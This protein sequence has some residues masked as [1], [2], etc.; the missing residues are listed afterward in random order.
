MASVRFPSVQA[1]RLSNGLAVRT[2]EHPGPPLVTF[3]LTMPAGSAS[4]P[5]GRAGL[6]ALT[7]DLFDEGSEGRT[8]LEL[9]GA[10]DRIGARFGTGVG[11]DATTVSLTTLSRHAAAGLALLAEIVARPRFDE[12]D[13]ARVRELRRSRL[14]QLRTV[15]G[16]VADRVYLET[17]Y[18]AHP[19]GHLGIGTDVS[20]AALTVEHVR[21]FH[22]DAYQLGTATL[23]AVGALTHDRFV[24]AAERAFGEVPVCPPDDAVVVDD[25]KVLLR[26]GQQFIGRD[27]ERVG[28][29]HGAEAG[30]HRFADGQQCDVLGLDVVSPCRQSVPQLVQDHA[31]EDGQDEGH[32]AQC[33]RQGL[34]GR[35]VRNE[36]PGQQQQ[37][38]PHQH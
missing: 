37:K 29:A 16:A 6:A 35:E 31:H 18:P 30:H 17:L 5:A 32:A 25:G 3:L 7:A 28:L 4:D 14:R 36:D 21:Q 2:V 8:A 38:R 20:L 1:I 10:L 23:I 22:R 34:A 11:T 26:A 24:E 12:A 9:H 19:Y 15:P 13:V 27:L 33:D